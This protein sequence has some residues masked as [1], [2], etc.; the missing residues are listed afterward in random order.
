MLRS[1]ETTAKYLQKR[2]FFVLYKG[3]YF[4]L[5]HFWRS[6]CILNR[7]KLQGLFLTKVFFVKRRKE[8]C[9]YVIAN[10]S[11]GMFIFKS[12]KINTQLQVLT[13]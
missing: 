2:Y 3:T 5:A 10:K 9:K 12:F 4:L 7:K 6:G 13:T 8:L 1:L 11:L